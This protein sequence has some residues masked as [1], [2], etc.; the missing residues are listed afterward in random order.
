MKIFAGFF[1]FIWG[2]FNFIRKLVMGV[3]SIIILL[4]FVLAWSLNSGGSSVS[5]NHENK[6]N[7]LYLQLGANLKDERKPEDF[8]GLLQQLDNNM[9]SE[10]SSLFDLLYAVKKA[11]NDDD[12]KAIVLD[13]NDLKG[14]SVSM[15]DEL[16]ASLE[17]FKQA[18]KKIYA[19]SQNFNSKNYLLASYADEILYSGGDF[20]IFDFAQTHLFFTDTLKELGVKTH[21]F[22][23]GTY[24]AAVEPFMNTELSE[25]ARENYSKLLNQEYASFKAILLKNRQLDLDKINEDF[26]VDNVYKVDADPSE[27]LKKLNFVD[28]IMPDFAISQYFKN[29]YGS[30]ENSIEDYDLASNSYDLSDYLATLTNRYSSEVNDILVVNVEGEIDG[31]ESDEKKAGASTIV[32]Q[33]LQAKK[34]DKNRGI[35]LR[36]N[37]PGGGVIASDEIYQALLDYKTTGRKVVASMGDLAA[38]GGYWVAMAADK[39]IATPNTLTGSIGVFGM[40]FNLSG[41]AD[42]VNLHVDKVTINQLGEDSNLLPLNPLQQKLNQKAVEQTYRKFISIVAK[43]RAMTLAQVDNLAQGKVY[44]GLDGFN[45]KLVDELGDFD[46]AVDSMAQLLKVPTSELNIKWLSPKTS[47]LQSL[48]TQI[49]SEKMKI[50]YSLFFA[51]SD[52]NLKSI[53]KKTSA[54]IIGVKYNDPKNQ[55]SICEICN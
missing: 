22:R 46:S 48:I 43:N 30:D 12:I 25:A 44:N 42:L 29:L 55:Y 52:L 37:S 6:P 31:G 50:V 26:M 28:Q 36:I 10:D 3:L 45:Y 18:G 5:K 38:S 15:I 35:I 8:K 23:V 2:S 51:N 49:S 47:V 54:E 13:L 9:P 53:F 11:T 17:L 32:D 1:K 16:G 7:L 20:N 4:A 14:A 33:I 27:E 21:I 34:S 41:T 24:K 39:I 19:F 40:L